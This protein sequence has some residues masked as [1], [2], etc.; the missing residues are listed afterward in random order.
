MS[1]QFIAGPSGCGKST[2]AY[3]KLIDEAVRK[4]LERFFVIVPEQFTM[5]AQK[6]LTAIHPGHTILNIDILSF[7]RL[8]FRVFEEIGENQAPILEDMGKILILQKLINDNK[9]D[10]SI[11]DGLFNKS[12]AA[13]RVN[14]Q[15]SE[16][17]QYDIDLN[18]IDIEKSDFP[19]LLKRKLSDLKII[20]ERFLDYLSGKYLTAEEVPVVLSRTIE[21]SKML[22]DATVIFDGFTGFVPTQYYVVER[23]LKM[24]KKVIVIATADRTAGL[25]SNSAHSNLFHMTHTMISKLIELAQK[26]NVEVL[27]DI[28]IDDTNGRFKKNEALKFLEKNLFRYDY[29]KYLKKQESIFI[30]QCRNPE[31]EAEK[32]AEIILKLVRTGKYR[33]RDFAFITGNIDDY[34]DIVKN[35]FDAND[36]P[37]FIDKK[38]GIMSNPAVEFVRA[39]I[40]MA[41][42]NLSYKSVFRF[43]KTGMTSVTGDINLFE[44]YVLAFAIKGKKAYE[45]EWNRTSVTILQE[46]LPVLNIIRTHFIEYIGTFLEDFKKKNATVR[47]R[48]VALYELIE[49]TQLQEKC[50]LLEE[51][52]TD[53]SELAKAKEFSQIYKIIMDFL[54]KLVDIL[55]EEKVSIELYRKLI[56]TGFQ[57]ITVGI[58]PPNRDRVVAGDIERTRLNNIKVLFFAGLND[59]IVPKPVLR[60]SVLSE[61]DRRLLSE[62]NIMLSPDSREEMYR[63]RLYLYLN[64]TKP[65]DIL[66]LSY[67]ATNISGEALMPSYLINVIG[68]MF[69]CI[70]TQDMDNEAI[71]DRLQTVTG[72]EKVLLDGFDK[73]NEK[74]PDKCFNEI[75]SFMGRSLDGRKKIEKLINA[76]LY[77]RK[78]TNISKAAAEMLYGINTR[79]SASRLEKYGSCAFRHFLE[80]GALLKERE[81]FEFSPAD[82]GSILH[83]SIKLFCDKMEKLGIQKTIVN[84]EEAAD[85]AF[86]T[87]YSEHENAAYSASRAFDE[88]RLKKINRITA[89][90]VVEQVRRGEFYPAATEA[91]FMTEGVA[92]VIDRI[93]ICIHGDVDYIRIIDYKS[94]SREPNLNKFYNKI[95]IQLPLYITAAQELIGARHHKIIEPAGIYYYNMKEPLVDVESMD[96]DVSNDRKLRQLRLN[97]ISREEPEILMLMDES[98]K[99]GA[100]SD[101]INAEFNKRLNEDGNIAV[102]ART[103]TCSLNGFMTLEK[104]TK[105]MIKTM[106]KE[107]EAGNTA[108]SPKIVDG[109]DSCTYCPF[110]SVCGFDH[111][112][113]G[114]KKKSCDKLSDEEAINK[115]FKELKKGNIDGN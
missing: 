22:K 8:A 79:Y 20:S 21:N 49:K 74:Q 73:M 87:A 94:S 98:L 60:Q 30:T 57:E 53:K 97:G 85:E 103:K 61:P 78:D 107:I 13:A 67:S 38:N 70:K 72:R 106:R 39:A 19:E 28:W 9:K 62:T 51:N 10:L 48:T 100:K 15:L 25:R 14:S 68:D 34:A 1:L 102:S 36:I 92:G 59:G 7:N 76:A 31:Q 17:M 77:H 83:R 26:N 50:K 88:I 65:S 35:I 24:C 32:A 40:E 64:M 6:E 5:Q 95:Q 44:N 69:D 11:L 90:C 91:R 46:D 104:Y 56:E 111:K 86:E 93:D 27:K 99:P 66:Y 80:Y 110:S 108:I 52:F 115:M 96:E 29:K 37:V 12:G 2:Y 112:I 89:K 109:T 4:P 81:V 55:G 54:N 45:R 75:V 18:S 113:P 71:M 41:S 84:I 105:Y 42:D 23:L 43:L 82:I 101:I 16:F 33:F 58:I 114:F 63:Q 3:I 47:Q